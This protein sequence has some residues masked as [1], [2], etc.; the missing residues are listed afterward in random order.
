MYISVR[1][2]RF[3]PAIGHWVMKYMFACA[4][5]ATFLNGLEVF[6]FR[7]NPLN[8]CVYVDF[9]F[10]NS[11]TEIRVSDGYVAVLFRILLDIWR[12]GISF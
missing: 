7:D 6:S 4:P 1:N 9:F 8:L 10:F 12:M 11:K 2:L 5:H 3:P